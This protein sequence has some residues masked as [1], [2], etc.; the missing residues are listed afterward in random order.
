MATLRITPIYLVLNQV[1]SYL[2]LVNYC[3]ARYSA[4]VIYA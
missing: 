2:T 1:K 4:R 3:V